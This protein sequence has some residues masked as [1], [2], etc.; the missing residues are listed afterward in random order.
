MSILCPSS[1]HRLSPVAGLAVLLTA[2]LGGR[3]A[4]AQ[5]YT[6]QDLGALPGSESFASALNATG[7][8]VG[9]VTAAGGHAHAVRWTQTGMQDLGTLGGSESSASSLNDAGEVAGT[10][11]LPGDEVRRAFLWSDGEM[12][13]LPTLG[14]SKSYASGINN[15]GQVVGWASTSGG[16]SHAFRFTHGQIEDLDTVG[17]GSSIATAINDAGQ[18]VVGVSDGGGGRAYLH[19]DGVGLVPLG[20]LGGIDSFGYGINS[21]GQ[22]V[23][24]AETVVN[25]ARHAFRWT[26]GQMEDLAALGDPERFF[27]GLERESVAYG[28]N[29]SGQVVGTFSTDAM[30]H[31]H[32]FLYT[33]GAGM[34]DLN[35]RIDPALGW[36]LEDARSIN[37]AGQIVG[38]G[39]HN[40]QRHAVR[41]APVRGGHLEVTPGQLTFPPGAVGST[42]TRSLLLKN[43]GTGPVAGRVGSLSA[44][45]VV[46]SGGAQFYLPPGGSATAQVQFAPGLR[47]REGPYTATC[48][49]T[50]SDPTA[51][52]TD[53][54]LTASVRW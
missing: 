35:E 25:R 8:V 34:A 30:S 21:L 42:A 46:V 1:G 32:A 19:T 52:R 27:S 17:G 54:P 43:V 49:I 13:L 33:D 14:G 37:D 18:V 47:L 51:A 23:G 26:N 16:A 2:G 6:V 24:E 5:V 3:P 48:V 45:F 41:L 9:I 40:G 50:S 39:A 44:P 7:Q 29:R 20:T 15:E 4:A 31:R 38:W 12:R 11:S 28:I 22:V 36:E 53:V 10:S